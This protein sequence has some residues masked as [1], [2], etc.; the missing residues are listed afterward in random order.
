M[1]LAAPLRVRMPLCTRS[2]VGFTPHLFWISATLSWGAYLLL[3]WAYTQS[4]R[5]FDSLLESLAKSS[6][7]TRNS[8]ST[9]LSPLLRL[10]S[11]RQR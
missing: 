10:T 4:A 3:V 2:L 11:A 6:A 7:T 1:P 8:N 5:V 9:Q